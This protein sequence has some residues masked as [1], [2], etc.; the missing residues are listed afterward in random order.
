MQHKLPPMKA[1]VALRIIF[2]E[3]QVVEVQK[4]CNQANESYE[5]L[6]PFHL[7]FGCLIPSSQLEKLVHVSN[8][9]LFEM[10]LTSTNVMMF[11]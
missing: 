7:K 8:K 1:M 6:K 4:H 10:E 11:N 5:V 2:N 9:W 3:R